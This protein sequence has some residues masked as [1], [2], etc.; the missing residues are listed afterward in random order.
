MSET[1][2]T[3]SV[4]S[5]AKGHNCSVR[6]LATCTSVR[7]D[8]PSDSSSFLLFSAGGKGQMCVWRVHSN[9]F[10]GEERH[11]TSIASASK[12]A[13]HSIKNSCDTAGESCSLDLSGRFCDNPSGWLEHLASHVRCP[14]GRRCRKP[15]KKAS[16]D[17]TPEM[18]YMKMCAFRFQDLLP[19]VESHLHI[20]VAV[21][22]VGSIRY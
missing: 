20:V 7:Q 21:C 8:M 22:S 12:D 4:L 15:W 19:N 13:P 1:K 18:R 3:I 17:P 2:S 10:A 14:K 6:T 5:S 9:I 11:S 16:Y